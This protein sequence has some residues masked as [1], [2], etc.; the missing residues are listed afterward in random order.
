MTKITDM[1]TA[2]LAE[3][4]DTFLVRNGYREVTTFFDARHNDIILRCKSNNDTGL[5]VVVAVMD[6]STIRSIPLNGLGQSSKAKAKLKR[7]KEW[8]W[9]QGIIAY[10]LDALWVDDGS[11]GRGMSFSHIMHVK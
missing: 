9:K 6:A 4:A 1:H 5:Y 11:T 7:I 10:R 8:A 2:T 3:M